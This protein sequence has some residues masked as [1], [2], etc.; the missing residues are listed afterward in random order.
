MATT[1][2]TV[3]IN[4]SGIEKIKKAISDY[5]SAVKKKADIGAKKSVIEKA[6]KGTKS[7][8]ALKTLCNTIDKEINNMLND[9]DKYSKYLDT[10]AATYKKSD[11]DNSSFNYAY[12]SLST[13]GN[14]S[15]APGDGSGKK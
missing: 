13:G 11:S 12:S 9:L 3:G 14:F 10:L 6:I 4:V 2:N 5:K 15:V 1:S 8:A 7:E